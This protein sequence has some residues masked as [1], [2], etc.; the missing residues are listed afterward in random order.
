MHPNTRKLDERSPQRLSSMK[1]AKESQS[2]IHSNRT[3]EELENRLSSNSVSNI[4][5]LNCVKTLGGFTYNS[6]Q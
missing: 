6:G 3:N 2:P 5:G 1:S 4:L